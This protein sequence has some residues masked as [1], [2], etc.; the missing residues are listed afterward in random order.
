M[1]IFSFD[2]YMP[3][4]PISGSDCEIRQEDVLVISDG[5]FIGSK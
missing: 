4:D 3:F 5:D 1:T 2:R